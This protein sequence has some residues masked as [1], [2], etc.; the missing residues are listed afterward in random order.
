MWQR[1]RI[2]VQP[3]YF[4]CLA[5]KKFKHWM[6]CSKASAWWA[7]SKT[8]RNLLWGLPE[9]YLFSF[10]LVTDIPEKRQLCHDIGQCSNCHQ[11]NRL[12]HFHLSTA[13]YTVFLSITFQ[14]SVLYAYWGKSF[15]LPV[16]YTFWRK[17]CRQYS[18]CFLQCVVPFTAH[19]HFSYYYIVHSFFLRFLCTTLF[20][21]LLLYIILVP[22]T[23]V[24]CDFNTI[25][26]S[27]PA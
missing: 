24:E 27:F 1:D 22:N 26:H 21:G 8:H 9:R 11:R 5:E 2:L 16:C 17:H 23:M 20:F 10:G 14:F 15:W 25:V 3:Y 19:S 4:L 7:A 6:Y 18:N 13:T 12:R